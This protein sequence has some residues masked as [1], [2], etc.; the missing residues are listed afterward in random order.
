M[1]RRALAGWLATVGDRGPPAFT[2]WMSVLSGLGGFTE[3]LVLGPPPADWRLWFEQF[4][5]VEEVVHGRATGW[6]H[7]SLYEAAESYL[8]QHG[9]PMDV[10]ASLEL[11]KGLRSLDLTSSADAADRLNVADPAARQLIRPDVLL[12]AVVAAYL[13]AGRPEKARAAL[14]ALA[15]RTGRPADHVRNLALDALVDAEL[16]GVDAPK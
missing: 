3:S 14:D 8:A 9:A 10:Q 1:E 13:G 15:P 2:E 5:L 6:V 4:E 12:D 11:L 7:E 16:V